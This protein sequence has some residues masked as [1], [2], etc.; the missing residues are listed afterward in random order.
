MKAKFI[1][2]FSFTSALSLSVS[3]K[4]EKA[5]PV[6][7]ELE[8]RV[9][10]TKPLCPQKCFRKKNFKSW[11]CKNRSWCSNCGSVKSM[12][13][14]C[15]FLGENCKINADNIYGGLD[16]E[17]TRSAMSCYQPI[18]DSA[19]RYKAEAFS[20][21][22]WATNQVPSFVTDDYDRHKWFHARKPFEPIVGDSTVI[23]GVLFTFTKSKLKLSA[24][25]PP[26]HKSE[27]SRARLK[28][29]AK[30]GKE[31]EY[32]AECDIVPNI[33]LCSFQVDDLPHN[34]E[35]TYSVTY[36]PKR[37]GS[38]VEYSYDGS[39]PMQVS[40][41]RIAA[42]GCFGQ[43]AVK[44]KDALVD[45]VLSHSPDLVVLQ[46]DQTYAH[47]HR[48]FGFLETIYSINRLT[49]SIPTIVQMDD[50]DYGQGN[51]WGAATGAANSGAG[52]THEVCIVNALER[53]AMSHNPDPISD[54]KLANGIA[55]Y[56]TN[57]MYGDLDIAVLEAR[58]FKNSKC[59]ISTRGRLIPIY[60]HTPH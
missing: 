26:L 5:E 9:L 14:T 54:K 44:E 18:Q 19:I 20:L 6:F 11:I 55:S 43:D 29:K 24:I 35:Y 1:I 53:L 10:Y 47:M 52:F 34:E 38:D 46:G 50:H 12:W 59:N 60:S 25:F 36:R 40:L 2:F 23:A 3:A 45:A 8:K 31:Q 4:E 21:V 17:R 56:Y 51:I 15:K 13:K 49:R 28:V 42:L 33:W 7:S 30:S 16:C 58:K 37:W 22:D 27:S 41:P 48:G 57:Y 39:I 32:D